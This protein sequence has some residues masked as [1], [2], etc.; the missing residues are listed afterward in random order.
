[1]SQNS[2]LFRLAMASRELSMMSARQQC[3]SHQDAVKIGV[4]CQALPAA[5]ACCC[6]P[7]G[8]LCR[9]GPAPPPA[10]RLPSSL[11]RESGVCSSAVKAKPASAAHLCSWGGKRKMGFWFGFR[12]QLFYC[13]LFLLFHFFSFSSRLLV[14]L[15]Y[16]DFISITRGRG[17]LV[18]HVFISSQDC[19]SPNSFNK[20]RIPYHS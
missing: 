10:A 18:P 14:L 17:N 9:C 12:F 1:M 16:H 15:F 4:G 2:L 20:S 7:A 13:F 5:H 11:S 8:S 3:N 19:K 6:W